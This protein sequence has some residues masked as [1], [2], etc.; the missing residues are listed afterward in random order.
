MSTRAA[1]VCRLDTGRAGGDAVTS[2]VACRSGGRPIPQTIVGTASG[3]LIVVSLET[4][5]SSTSSSSAAA[6]D[7]VSET[8]VSEGPAV[9]GEK[10][11]PIQAR[12]CWE[13]RVFDAPISAVALNAHGD[14]CAVSCV[15]RN[16]VIRLGLDYVEDIPV[17]SSARPGWLTRLISLA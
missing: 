15:S 7:G 17:K 12:A 1:A 2:I 11:E 10:Q 6:S 3:M 14:C 4:S 16:Q 9:M 5:S 8:L 13:L